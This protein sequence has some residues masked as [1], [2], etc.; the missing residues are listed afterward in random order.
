M[1][2]EVII[3]LPASGKSYLCKKFEKKGYVVYD[4]F[5]SNFYNNELLNDDS[6]KICIADPRLCNFETFSRFIRYFEDR[7][8]HLTLFENN[9]Q[10]CFI[11]C[12][13]RNTNIMKIKH[14]IEFLSKIYNLNN[15]NGNITILP[16]YSD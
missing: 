9:P 10:L 4:D 15:Y 7:D 8:I 14:S 11:N 12:E 5:I 1:S 3:G 2:L 6:E 13:R 16:V